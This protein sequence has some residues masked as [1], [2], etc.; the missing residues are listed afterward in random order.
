MN[1]LQVHR[2]YRLPSDVDTMTL[3]TT[4]QKGRL[5]ITAKKKKQEPDKK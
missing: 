3:K 2:A 4:L 1:T 5:V